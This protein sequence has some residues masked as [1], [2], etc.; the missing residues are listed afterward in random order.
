MALSNRVVVEV[1]RRSDLHAA[2]SKLRIDIVVGDDG[3]RASGEGQSHA[4]ADPLRVSF[5]F[6]VYGDGDVAEHRFR[7]RRGDDQRAAAVLQRI[8]YL[9]DL[10]V[11][12][13]AVHFEIGHRR[14]ELR[15]PVDETLAAVDQ[16]LLVKP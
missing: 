8:A 16:A 9:P 6:R 7:S 4:L 11:F 10:P 2:G 13:L 12:L 1:V 5:V 14:A 3:D 15:V